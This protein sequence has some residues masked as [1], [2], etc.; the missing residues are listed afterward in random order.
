M[1]FEPSGIQRKLV[2]IASGWDQV[3]E[4]NTQLYDAVLDVPIGPFKAGECVECLAFNLH[5]NEVGEK[6]LIYIYHKGK[7]YKFCVDIQFQ[8]GEPEI[9]EQ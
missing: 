6:P 7:E 4:F 9:S 8:F 3:D 5:R 1:P 2:R